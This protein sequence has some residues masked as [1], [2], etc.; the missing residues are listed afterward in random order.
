M[1][2]IL[3]YVLF[4]IVKD[5]PFWIVSNSSGYSL[6]YVIFLITERRESWLVNNFFLI[7]KG[8]F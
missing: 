7:I 8:V 4:V 6:G 1:S 5:G 2:G 3:V